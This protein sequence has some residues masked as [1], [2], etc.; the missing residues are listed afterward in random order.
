MNKK[1]LNMSNPIHPVHNKT[2][3]SLLCL[4]EEAGE[5]LE[6][7]NNKQYKNIEN[8]FNETHLTKEAIDF[9]AV[10][11][12][13]IQMGVINENILFNAIDSGG[14]TAHEWE[15]F[16]TTF[17]E[18]IQYINTNLIETIIQASKISRFGFDKPENILEK[19]DSNVEKVQIAIYCAILGL[20]TILKN[21]ISLSDKRIKEKQDKVLKYMEVS[22]QKGV[23]IA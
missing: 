4:I 9:I 15:Y 3:H 21:N 22:K 23:L 6:I 2:Q 12:I 8:S 16:D 17:D 7:L 11:D 13:L 10:A 14:I 20:V 19:L 5:I 18:H 1:A